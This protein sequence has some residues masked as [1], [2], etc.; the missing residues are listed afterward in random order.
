VARVGRGGEGEQAIGQ[1][2]KPTLSKLSNLAQWRSRHS[3]MTF[4]V[5]MKVYLSRNEEE[6]ILTFLINL[7]I[8]RHLVPGPL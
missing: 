5:I 3:N 2:Q 7:C 1:G 6:N 8:F 4:Q